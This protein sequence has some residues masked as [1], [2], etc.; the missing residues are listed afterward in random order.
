LKT[1]LYEVL[2]DS[3]QASGFLLTRGGRFNQ[4]RDVLFSAL[5][6][7]FRLEALLR[8][9]KA[10]ADPAKRAVAKAAIFILKAEQANCTFPAKQDEKDRE[11][12]SSS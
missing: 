1:P 7:T 11:I 2:Q 4:G 9:A 10:A 5:K 6:A 3:I 8:G 12:L